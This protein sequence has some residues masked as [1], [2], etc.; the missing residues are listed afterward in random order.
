V[1]VGLN[2]LSLFVADWEPRD[3]RMLTTLLQK[4]EI[5]KAAVAASERQPVGRRRRESPPADGGRADHAPG[6]RAA[7]ETA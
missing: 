3:V 2:R 7:P 4:F 5:S 1:H 6:R